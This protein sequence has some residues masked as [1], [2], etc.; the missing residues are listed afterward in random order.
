MMSM[1]VEKTTISA[2]RQKKTQNL[3][4]NNS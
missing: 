2:Q 1:V 3:N 4:A